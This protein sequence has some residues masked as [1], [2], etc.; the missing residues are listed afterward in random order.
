MADIKAD[1][2]GASQDLQTIEDFVNL[3][4]G[5]DVRPRLLP[6]VNVGTL[7]GTRDAIFKAGGLPA[8]PFETKAQ[9]T[10]EGASLP[11]GQLAMV[12]NDTANNG[13]YVKTA[14][15]WVKSSY[16]PVKQSK[17][18]ADAN[19]MFKPQYLPTS[20][21]NI[22]ALVEPGMYMA[23]SDAA[24]VQF[25]LPNGTAGV[26][27]VTGSYYDEQVTHIYISK[28][29]ISVRNKPKATAW[30][31]W[32]SIFSKKY[33]SAS[34]NANL[35]YDSG[36]YASAFNGVPPVG[37][38]LPYP[39]DRFTLLVS[40][41][42]SSRQT[43]FSKSGIAFRTADS[44]GVWSAWVKTDPSTAAFNG[45]SRVD[46]RLLVTDSLND[47]LYPGNYTSSISVHSFDNAVTKSPFEDEAVFN[48]RMDN[49]G[50]TARQYYTSGTGIASRNARVKKDVDGKLIVDTALGDWT[51]WT[52]IK[53]PTIGILDLGLLKNKVDALEAGNN[54]PKVIYG[55]GS[56][57]LEL[58]AS[59]FTA[60]AER[61][62]HVYI[63]HGVSGETLAVSGMHQGSNVVTLKFSDA[64]LTNGTNHAVTITQ[65]FKPKKGRAYKAVELSNGVKGLLYFS[66]NN[67]ALA[68]TFKPTNL[69]EPLAVDTTYEYRAINPDFINQ[70]KGLYYFDIGKNNMGYTDTA[71]DIVD[72][73]QEMIDYIPEG[74][75]YLVGGHFINTGLGGTDYGNKVA[76]VNQ[77]LKLRYG[78]RFCDYYDFLHDDAVWTKYGITKTAEDI[79]AIAAGELPP[80]LGRD[81]GTGTR[82]TAHLRDEMSAEIAL[83]AEARFIELGYFS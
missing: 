35:F 75:E 53:Y 29:G 9:M 67:G 56:S 11:D 74:S 10:S 48:V 71:Q 77:M 17:E 25:G 18:Y 40:R 65:S 12:H 52:G 6:S 39:D 28:N 82:D 31:K 36:A 46:E 33:F 76:A 80:S 26:L 7:A 54:T 19:A 66:E 78:L 21:T 4:A 27:W 51:P 64:T 3:P 63:G 43:Y 14:G 55:W 57:T 34:D 5:S 41:S 42:S 81:I 38:N 30:S 24:A 20:T 32:E 44:A 58:A 23:H 22:D 60:M 72:A 37:A 73:Q 59:Y 61:H 70:G 15:T 47:K 45:M 2:A 8:E 49:T 50:S 62:S 68:N 13:L 69:T 16:D 1:I 83:Q 79:A